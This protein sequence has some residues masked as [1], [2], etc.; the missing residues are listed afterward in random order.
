MSFLIPRKTSFSDL[1]EQVIASGLREGFC[2]HL[3]EASM[4]RALDTW[5]LSIAMSPDVEEPVIRVLKEVLNCSL[6]S[7]P[8]S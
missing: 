8:S 1:V 6:S 4:T 3:S 2:S 5:S 7:L